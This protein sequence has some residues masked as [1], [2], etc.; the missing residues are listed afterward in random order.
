MTVAASEP[1]LAQYGGSE[2]KSLKNKTFPLFSLL[3]EL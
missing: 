2:K 1:I 3:K